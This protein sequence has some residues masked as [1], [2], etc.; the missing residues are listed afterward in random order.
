[1]KAKKLLASALRQ[2][3][4]PSR[5]NVN[6]ALG[7]AEDAR[8]SALASTISV[9]NI[10]RQRKSAGEA[11]K[12]IRAS[13]DAVGYMTAAA[14]LLHDALQGGDAT[15]AMRKALNAVELITNL[16]DE[17]TKSGDPNAEDATAAKAVADDLAKR[18]RVLAEQ[19]QRAGKVKGSAAPGITPNVVQNE[20]GGDVGV[21]SVE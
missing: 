13:S 9:R 2:K 14:E 8:L 12:L 19:A 18:F 7:Y 3:L 15:L 5:D 1:M 4:L 6:A 17:A 21:Q 11:A 10:I 20:M 16:A